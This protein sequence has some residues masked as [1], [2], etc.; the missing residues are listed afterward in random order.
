M[1]GRLKIG[2]KLT[3]AVSTSL[4]I[5]LALLGVAVLTLVAS[6]TR[7]LTYSQAQE[8]VSGKAAEI[9]EFFVQRGR[10]ATTMLAN[11]HL[12]DWFLA[13]D[14]FR[15][16]VANDPDYRQII[17]Y[18]DKIVADDPQIV[19]AFFATENTQEYF[20]AGDGRIERD[21]YFVKSREWW[22][23]AVAK[24]R[25]YV[26]S[27]DVS[28]STGI[29]AV[30]IHTTVYRDDGTLFGVGGVDLSLDVFGGLIDEIKLQGSE[31]RAF[32]V[33]EM[34]QVIHFAGVDLE[35][36]TTQER[37]AVFLAS[38]DEGES[39]TDGFQELSA[40]YAEGDTSPHE[41]TWRGERSIVLAAPVASEFPEL[42]WTLGIVVPDRVI[43]APVHRI[44]FVS[45]LSIILAIVIVSVLTL[46][47]S[48]I[49]VVRP[50]RRL[51]AR[52]QDI[53]QGEGDLR[54]RV[55]VASSDEVG[56]LGEIF[57]SFLDRLQRDISAV[58]EN[59]GS[60]VSASDNLQVLSQE[61]A[62]TTEQTS[63]QAASVSDASETVNAHI[64][65][66]A[67]A[68]EQMNSNIREIAQFARQ[69]ADVATEGVSVAAE[70]IATFDKLGKS[71][72]T[73]G[74]VVEVIN[75]VAQQTNL[76]AL[77]A[78]IEA[79]RA[80]DSGKGFAVVAGEVKNLAKETAQ[81]T[82]EISNT[83]NALQSDASVA[84]E[85]IERISNIIQTIFEIQTTI[86]GAVEEQT[87]TTNEIM[88][89]ASAAATT[90]H[91]IAD[92]IAG[93]AQAVQSSA[94]SAVVSQQ[95]ATDLA[96]AAEA[97]TTIVRRFS[98]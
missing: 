38:F 65:T 73:I 47:A 59:A 21:G 15:A 36:D 51:L 90:S 79:A 20:R 27:P 32:L 8:V 57:N 62:S 35:L 89:S 75:A 87:A 45:T 43:S 91:D 17:T 92:S 42:N 28:A 74:K 13:Y 4:T 82:E 44:V 83:I 1:I 31:G 11:P 3:I 54:R 69:A 37:P 2:S 16:P 12:R 67:S 24:D 30:V 41:V 52:F 6:L 63:A 19:Q 86:S 97:L 72:L 96:V 39:D 48:N 7:Q 78:T 49:V 55:D 93:T 56:K 68:T 58:G 5:S 84:S 14:Q 29:V 50:I 60:L 9:R 34:G 95:A 94:A 53:A 88:R 33:N 22:Q 76:L 71:T 77:N 18:F 25:L 61:I 64:H 80:G 98:Y 46:S 81:A 26:T 10:V 85:A 23:E 66:V 40:F 70:S